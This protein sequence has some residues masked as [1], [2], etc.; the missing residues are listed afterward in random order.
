MV[1]S[2]EEPMTIRPRKFRVDKNLIIIRPKDFSDLKSLQKRLKKVG[3]DYGHT[4]IKPQSITEIDYQHLMNDENITDTRGIVVAT[5]SDNVNLSSS[6]T[7]SSS[8]TTELNKEVVVVSSSAEPVT[9]E[10]QE[11]EKSNEVIHIPSFHIME[12]YEDTLDEPF[13]LPKNSYIQYEQPPYDLSNEYDI[14]EEDDQFLRECM[15]HY[16]TYMFERIMAMLSRLSIAHNAAISTLAVMDMCLVCD[17]P[18]LESDAC[19]IVQYFNSKLKKQP[20]DDEEPGKFVQNNRSEKV[21]SMENDYLTMF[22]MRQDFER[23]RILVEVIRKRETMKL[24]KVKVDLD[25]LKLQHKL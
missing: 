25:I 22:K 23:L 15:P 17:I 20:N 7:T 2:T 6:T 13:R 12:D 5:T 14:T 18:I 4:K 24:R 9:T 10:P 3:S 19:T 16:D 1:K 11:K 21:I 8:N